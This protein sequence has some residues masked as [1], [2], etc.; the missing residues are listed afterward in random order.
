MIE[1]TALPVVIISFFF[2]MCMEHWTILSKLFNMRKGEICL[3]FLVSKA[4]IIEIPFEFG[5][6][7]IDDNALLT[8]C[9]L[10]D[11]TWH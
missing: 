4:T 3:L 11:Y 9:I 5:A 7:D 8:S 1:G 10:P 2:P 6:S